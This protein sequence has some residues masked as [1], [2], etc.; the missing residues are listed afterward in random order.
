MKKREL[1]ELCDKLVKITGSPEAAFEKLREDERVP[2]SLFMWAGTYMN[3]Q[4]N[5]T[6]THKFEMGAK[7]RKKRGVR[8]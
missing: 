1:M 8:I 5:K 3:N 6:A 4:Y 7:Q 2:L